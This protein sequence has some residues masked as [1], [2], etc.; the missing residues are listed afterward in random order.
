MYPYNPLTFHSPLKIIAY[1]PQSAHNVLMYIENYITLLA[2]ASLLNEQENDMMCSFAYQIDSG[3]PLTTRQA[4]RAKQI[5]TRLSHDSAICYKR[6][7]NPLIMVKAIREDKWKILPKESIMT[8]REARYIG[9]NLIALTLSSNTSSRLSVKSMGGNFV[10][11]DGKGFYVI[12][13]TSDNIE[14]LLC[15]IARYDITLDHS[16]NDFFERCIM[17]EDSQAIMVNNSVV[18]SIHSDELLNRYLRQ[19]C[20]AEVI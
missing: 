3:R 7:I 17:E 12:P 20:G 1:L 10:F 15:F 4:Y 9:D 14:D 8:E 13:V 19:H 5:L 11:K 18:F 16:T 2:N 6:G